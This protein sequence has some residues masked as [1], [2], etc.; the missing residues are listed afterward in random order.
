MPESRLNENLAHRDYNVDIKKIESDLKEALSFSANS[1]L[2]KNPAARRRA[3]LLAH[4]T[5]VSALIR[6]S[7]TFMEEEF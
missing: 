5:I 1:I 7:P 4:Q 6:F 3:A 2:A